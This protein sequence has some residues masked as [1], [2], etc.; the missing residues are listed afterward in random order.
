MYISLARGSQFSEIWIVHYI[1]AIEHPLP[2]LAA[3][4]VLLSYSSVLKSQSQNTGFAVLSSFYIL[5][6]VKFLIS[7]YFKQ[8][9]IKCFIVGS[10]H[11]SPRFIYLPLLFQSP[12][13][14]PERKRIHRSFGSPNRCSL[15]FNVLKCPINFN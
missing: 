1:A 11:W 12:L 9:M 15:P 8:L 5:S 4:A 6:G 7:L 13:Y 3:H 2:Y 10:A 14:Q